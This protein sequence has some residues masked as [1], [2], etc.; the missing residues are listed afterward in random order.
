MKKRI[1]AFAAVPFLLI[2]CGGNSPEGTYSF[3]MGKEKGSHIAINLDLSKKDF[4]ADPTKGK[5]FTLEIVAKFNG[6]GSSSE[7]Q[8]PRMP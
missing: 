6:A 2:S 4:E 8:H 3:Q 1:L 5:S 7:E